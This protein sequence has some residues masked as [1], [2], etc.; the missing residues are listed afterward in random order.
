MPIPGLSRLDHVGFTV[1]DLGQAAEFLVDVLGCTYLYALGP[2]RDDAGHWMSEH[3]GVDDR[4]VIHRIHFFRFGERT[5]FEVFEY[6]A[7]GRAD[8][9][10]RNSDVGGHHLALYVADLDSRRSAPAR[11]ARTGRADRRHR[12]PRGTALGVLPVALGDAV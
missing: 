8:T 6:E 12:R 7:P 11:P 4:A 10:P 3:L 1:P 5:L 9:P 2:Y